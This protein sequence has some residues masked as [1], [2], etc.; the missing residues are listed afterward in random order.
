MLCKKGWMLSKVS[1]ARSAWRLSLEP[2]Y[3]LEH[4]RVRR[5]AGGRQPLPELRPNRPL[6]PEAWWVSLGCSLLH[7]R[8]RQYQNKPMIMNAPCV[9]MNLSFL[10]CM[11]GS[12]SNVAMLILFALLARKYGCDEGC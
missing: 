9:R 12:S 3:R 8:C 7:C 4:R 11:A 5:Q 1:R 2:V 10:V 6:L